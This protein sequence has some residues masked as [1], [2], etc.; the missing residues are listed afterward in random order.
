MRKAQR[1]CTITVHMRQPMQLFKVLQRS[2]IRWLMSIF[3]FIPIMQMDAHAFLAF[4]LLSQNLQC[5]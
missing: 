1:Q 3:D 4:L 2:A 5:N